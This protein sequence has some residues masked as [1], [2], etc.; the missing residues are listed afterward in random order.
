MMDEDENYFTII[1]LCNDYNTN[2]RMKLKPKTDYR[3]YNRPT[4]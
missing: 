1:A 3:N 4:V 2:I